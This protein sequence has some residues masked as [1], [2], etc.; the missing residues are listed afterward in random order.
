MNVPQLFPNLFPGN[1]NNSSPSSSLSASSLQ[2]SA[3]PSLSV[4]IQGDQDLTP[5]DALKPDASQQMTTASLLS[6][7]TVPSPL[8][9]PQTSNS[10]FER[11]FSKTPTMPTLLGDSSIDR[12]LS[13]LLEV[14]DWILNGANN[15]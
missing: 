4:S 12:S 14:E 1:P 10:S 2:Y 8:N 13:E 3:P 15:S 7:L 9:V 11:P 6:L 5:T